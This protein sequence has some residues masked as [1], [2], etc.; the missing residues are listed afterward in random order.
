MIA[1]H[2]LVLCWIRIALVTDAICHDHSKQD[3]RVESAAGLASCASLSIAR[4][5]SSPSPSSSPHS[6]ITASASFSQRRH[7]FNL[8][9]CDFNLR[10]QRVRA[11][12]A[13]EAEFMDKAIYRR[14]D[15]CRAATRR[16]M[17]C[18][19]RRAP[20]GCII[21]PGDGRH[22]PQE[23]AKCSIDQSRLNWQCG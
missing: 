20:S 17:Y 14:C 18:A 1:R 19:G 4:T 9:T 21:S 10:Q 16:S 23:E 5:S 7:L 3:C 8:S 12:S 11:V 6:S 2:L 15:N 22:H 13:N